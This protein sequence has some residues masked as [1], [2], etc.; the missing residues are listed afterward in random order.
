NDVS[1]LVAHNYLK[2]VDRVFVARSDCV[3][4]RYVDDTVIFTTS[5]KGADELKRSHHL[6]LREI[7]LNP[8]AAK[9]EILAVADFEA[10][11]HRE[12]NAAIEE[13]FRRK[14]TTVFE[15][16]VEDWLSRTSEDE[17]DQVTKRLY[18]FA[19]QLKSHSLRSVVSA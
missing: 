16:L 13:T 1:R 6:A 4:L 12:F 9:S 5:A 18:T 17:W 19:R 2:Q 10:K 14:D 8:N 7:G 15:C 11:R 3:Y